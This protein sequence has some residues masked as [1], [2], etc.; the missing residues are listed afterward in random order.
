M[1]YSTLDALIPKAAAN[2]ERVRAAAERGMAEAQWLLGVLYY[3]GR[4]VAQNYGQAARWFRSAANQGF[5]GAQ[6]H[7]GLMY[8][9]GR[10]VAQ[11]DS[12]AAKC[13][14]R[15]AEQGDVEA[16][17][18]LGGLYGEGRGVAQGRRRSRAHGFVTPPNRDW[19][20]PKPIW[21]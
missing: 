5:A 18:N 15:A 7:L 10:G 12:A 2:V 9:H 21:R 11:D 20:P 14:R 13:Y 17:T 1:G 8:Q 19:R 16:Q 3:R 4:G 6:T